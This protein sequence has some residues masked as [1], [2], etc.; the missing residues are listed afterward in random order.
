MLRCCT[1][2]P[3]PPPRP[4]PPPPQPSSFVMRM[5]APTVCYDG[6]K[7]AQVQFLGRGAARTPELRGRRSAQIES[8]FSHQATQSNAAHITYHNK[9]I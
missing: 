4:P 9:H 1:G 8:C 5:D 6:V 7:R 3:P 2:S